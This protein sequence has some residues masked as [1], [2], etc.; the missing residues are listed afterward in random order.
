MDN[1]LE[2]VLDRVMGALV[3]Q[4][5]EKLKTISEGDPTGEKVRAF[6]VT[7]VPNL[8]EIMKEEAASNPPQTT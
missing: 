2:K 1:L 8:E 5:M 3:I 7:K 6:L 4:D